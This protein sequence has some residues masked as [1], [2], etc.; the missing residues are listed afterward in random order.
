ML[1]AR[2]NKWTGFLLS[3]AVPGSGQLLAR[4]PTALS[5]FV[6]AGVLAAVCGA[7]PAAGLGPLGVVLQLA[8]W[9]VFNVVSAVDAL[10][11]LEPSPPWR[12]SGKNK[13]KVACRGGTGRR[14]AASIR[15]ET[16]LSPAALW[17]R[18]SNLPV[19]LTIDPFH[20]RITLMRDR[21]AA[22]VHLVLHHNAFGRRFD[23][24]G[25]ILR[26][27]EGQGF[28]ISDLSGRNKRSGFPHI[29]IYQ[30]ESSDA[31]CATLHVEITGRWT[32]RWIPIWMGR[33]WIVGVCRY[34]AAL[35][36][37]AM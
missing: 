8:L 31:G 35:L 15:V 22:G 20:E 13:A 3:L 10:G 2:P 32:S 30:I 4:C 9:T 27:S 14:I 6:G 21:P 33:L 5:W 17:K 18:I 16:P 37:K 1:V 24:F 28:T 29:F 19:F 12:A 26:W 25:R 36:R 11:L 7:V 34:H 23:R